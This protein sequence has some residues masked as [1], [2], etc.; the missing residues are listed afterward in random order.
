MIYLDTHALVALYAGELNKIGVA[1]KKAIEQDELLASPA[2]VLE[3][4]LLHEIGRLRTP[5]ITLISGLGKQ[6]GLRVCDLPFS[7]VVDAALGEKW[8]RDPF[9]RLIVANAK[10]RRAALVTKD[11]RIHQHYSRAVW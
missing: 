8:G 1:G 4:E 3:L 5:A 10:A 2:A 11:Q 7:T 9:D 6:F